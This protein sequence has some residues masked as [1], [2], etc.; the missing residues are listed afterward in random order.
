ML[1]ELSGAGVDASPRAGGD[2]K[3]QVHHGLCEDLHELGL[4]RS[5]GAA[6]ECAVIDVRPRNSTSSIVRQI[7]SRSANV[8]PDS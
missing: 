6:D 2:G 7:G 8:F 3:G 4:S 5:G 1:R